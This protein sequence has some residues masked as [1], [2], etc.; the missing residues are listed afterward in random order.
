MTRSKRMQTIVRLAAHAGL[1]RAIDAV[2][3]AVIRPAGKHADPTDD[4]GMGQMQLHAHEAARGNT[5]DRGLVQVHAVRR[6]LSRFSLT[7]EQK[8]RRQGGRTP[9]QDYWHGRSP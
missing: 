5:R 2:A 3:S 9:L 4:R 6:Q 7:A 8:H 1:Q